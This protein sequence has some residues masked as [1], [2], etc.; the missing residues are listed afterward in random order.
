[1]LQDLIRKINIS[2]NLDI[3]LEGIYEF[4]TIALEYGDTNYDTPTKFMDNTISRLDELIEH[5]SKDM[6]INSIHV[7][8]D[9]VN[10]WVNIR[11]RM[12]K[13]RTINSTNETVRD[14]LNRIIE[15]ED[16][17]KKL[18]VELEEHLYESE[19]DKSFIGNFFD[20][21]SRML[22]A[23]LVTKGR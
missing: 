13:L 14:L 12:L 1:M 22:G 16:Y 8:A 2:N 11:K 21:L 9:S 20:G 4:I 23:H 18:V 6:K 10:R 15:E 5:E 7:Q 19:E 3:F 17:R